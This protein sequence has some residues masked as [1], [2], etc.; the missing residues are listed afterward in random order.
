MIQPAQ[1]QAIAVRELNATSQPMAQ[2]PSISIYG[3]RPGDDV[4]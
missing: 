3:D 2:V 1:E 4:T